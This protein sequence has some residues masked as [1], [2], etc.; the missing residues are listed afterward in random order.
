ME[1]GAS[2]LLELVWFFAALGLLAVLLAILLKVRLPASGA[3]RWMAR[4]GMIGAGVAATLLANVILYKHDAHLDFTRDRVFTPSPDAQRVVRGLS[5]DVQVTYFYQRNNPAAVGAKTILE[6]LGRSNP[7]LTVR[8]VD[9][10]Q[11]PGV[12]NRMGMKLYNAA[13]ITSGGR[14]IEVVSTDDRDIALGIIRIT[15]N[16]D[17]PVCFGAGQGEYDIDNFEFHTHFEGNGAHQHDGQ[18]KNLVNTE[19]HGVGRLRRALEQLGYAVRKVELA[20]IAA[21]PDNCAV[22]IEANPRYRFA[23][24]D[25]AKLAAYASQGGALMLL[26]EPDYPMD[27]PLADLL[28]RMGVAVADGVLADPKSHYFT[29][30]QMVAVSNYPSHPATINLGLSF[31]PGVR[32]LRLVEAKGVVAKVLLSSSDQSYPVNKA[33]PSDRKPAVQALGITAQ[34]TLDDPV[35][36]QGQAQGQAQ[37]QPARPFRL[38]VVGDADFASNSFF[39]YLGNSDLTL[40]LISWLRGEERGPAMKPTTEVLPTVV[41]TEVQMRNIFILTV[42]LLPGLAALLGFVMWWRRR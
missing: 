39:P 34:G 30:E 29:D 15:R 18:E 26:I 24:P 16:D 1:H 19:Q 11:N 33:Q 42:L 7:R 23:P 6:T 32:P 5:S 4:A 17:R 8:T 41:L 13:V 27:G 31:F 40:G 9:P 22:W 36:G 21:V 38:A 2:E 25:V 35:K 10:D 14:R 28:A 37:S 20:K 12:A 3:T